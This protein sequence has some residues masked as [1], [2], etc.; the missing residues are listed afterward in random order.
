MD[1]VGSGLDATQDLLNKGTKKAS[2]SLAKVASNAQ[3][4]K[5]SAQDQYASYQR[6]RNWAKMALRWGLVFGLLAALLFTPLTGQEMRQRL[7]N[8]WQQYR[9]YFGQ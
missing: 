7:A 2:K 4:L 5:E 3:D 9:S 6:R 8:Q 1:S